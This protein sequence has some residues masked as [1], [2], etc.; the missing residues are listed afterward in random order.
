MHTQ[1]TTN[2][3]R[4]EH[5]RIEQNTTKSGSRTYWNRKIVYREKLL[6]VQFSILEWRSFLSYCVAFFPLTLSLVYFF[7][8][9]FA[10]SVHSFV[11]PSVCSSVWL[12]VRLQNKIAT[13]FSF[14][15]RYRICVR[16]IFFLPCE[17]FI[18]QCSFF[19][20]VCFSV[21]FVRIG[22]NWTNKTMEN[23]D[24]CECDGALG[25]IWKWLFA[26]PKGRLCRR[27]RQWLCSVWFGFV[28]SFAQQ[29]LFALDISTEF[30]SASV[31]CE[32]VLKCSKNMFFPLGGVPSKS[33]SA[34]R[35]THAHTHL[36]IFYIYAL[37]RSMPWRFASIY[38]YMYVIY[39]YRVHRHSI[40]ICKYLKE[41]HATHITT[42]I[43]G[44]SYSHSHTQQN[45]AAYTVKRWIETG[46]VS[47]VKYAHCFECEWRKYTA[48]GSPCPNPSWT[49]WNDTK[50]NEAKPYHAEPSQA[51]PNI[52]IDIF[53]WWW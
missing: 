52:H 16:F 47:N 26:L 33:D 5:N 43:C 21:F 40:S 41:A 46:V 53:G 48:H 7:C 45:G 17:E 12:F 8:S 19:C 14:A 36:T 44:Y 39:K 49:E 38:K 2:F 24:V 18:R 35:Y 30:S 50:R 22:F 20:S 15:T 13:T 34:Y 31:V 29:L 1:S 51:M 9:S 37:V 42:R 23:A 32:L 4:T 10:C 6:S 27:N 11:P 28:L 25:V 3:N